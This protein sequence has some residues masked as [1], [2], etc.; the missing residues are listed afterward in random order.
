MSR[1]SVTHHGHDYT[2]TRDIIGISGKR[3]LSVKSLYL[4]MW[5]YACRPPPTQ[6]RLILQTPT[7][8]IE[9]TAAVASV[10]PDNGRVLR[11]AFQLLD[12]ASR[13]TAFD[14][15]RVVPRLSSSSY[16]VLILPDCI[17]TTASSATSST[18]PS[19]VGLCRAEVPV[20]AFPAAGATLQASMRVDLYNGCVGGRGD[21]H[22]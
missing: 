20:Q 14:F 15:L 3:A 7:L 11:F 4:H 6:I 22:A 5:R 8:V 18:L 1:N 12:S 13:P 10:T 21:P 17:I 16:S 9:P 2:C 19:G